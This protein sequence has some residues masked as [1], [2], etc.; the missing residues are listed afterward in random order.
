MEDM[1]RAR[2]V[3]RGVE[4]LCHVRGPLPTNRQV[5][6]NRKL[7]VSFPCSMILTRVLTDFLAMFFPGKFPLTRLIR[8][9]T[10]EG[11]QGTER[12][13]ICFLP[14]SFFGTHQTIPEHLI[15]SVIQQ[16][17]PAR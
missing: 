4:L 5:F 14:Q 17:R 6:T 11:I 1:G 16:L 10:W 13:E 2:Y 7:P 15:H 12:I 9:L 8:R 3:G